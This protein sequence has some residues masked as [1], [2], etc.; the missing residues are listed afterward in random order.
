M[1][2]FHPRSPQPASLGL[3]GLALLVLA[4]CGGKDEPTSHPSVERVF[5]AHPVTGREAALVVDEGGELATTDAAR[6]TVESFALHAAPAPTTLLTVDAPLDGSVFPAAFAPPTLLW[7]D[8]DS[9]ADTWLLEITFDPAAPA[10]RALL[11]GSPPAAGTIDPEAVGE[12]NEPYVP[13]PYQS[14]ARS[15]TPSPAVWGLIQRRSR[16]GRAALAFTGF[17]SDAPSR[18]LSHGRVTIRTTR[19]EL[20]APIFYRDVPL[21]PSAGDT[22][23][24]QPL[25]TN[26]LPVIGWRLRDVARPDSR[27][28][29][30]GM[31]SCANCHSFSQDGKTMGMDVDGPQGDKGAYAVA[32]VQKHLTITK[33]D[34]LTWNS[35]ADKPEGHRTIGFLS[36]VSPNGETVLS[37][38]NESLYVANFKDYRFLQVFFPTRGILAWWSR[39]TGR[40]QALPGADDP[41]YVHCDPVWSPDGQTVVFARAGAQDPYV[42]GRPLATHPNDPNE[43]QIRYDLYR[44]PFN[45]GRGGRPEPIAG[46]SSNGMSN[47]FPKI[48]P[49]GK[50]IVFVK[51]KNGQLMRP[52]GR[53]WI[54]PFEGGKAREMHCNTP[55]MNS[56]H[57][58]SPDSRWMVFS[59]KANTPYTQLFLTHIDE[60]GHDSPAILI[61]NSTAAN[62]AA[63]LPEFVNI[64]YDDLQEIEV[65]AANH[66][67]HYQRG[68]KDLEAGKLEGAVAHFDLALSEDPEFSQAHAALA[69]AYEGLGRLPDARRHYE[70]AL[71]VDARNVRVLNNLGLVLYQSG[72][73]AAAME[74]WRR[75]L[76]VNPMDPATHTNI[77]L[78]HARARRYAE[79]MRHFDQALEADPDCLMAHK[80]LA[81]IAMDEGR[82]PD[83]L[84]H[85]EAAIAL[86]PTDP[87]LRSR[88]LELL[89]SQRR[90][91]GVR[92][93]LEA[94]VAASPQD[95]R[96]RVGLAWLLATS[97]DPTPADI[98]AAVRLAEEAGRLTKHASPPALDALGVAYAA[99]GRYD[100]AVRAAEK[101][102]E[103]A[104]PRLAALIRQR[105][106]LYREQRPYR[107]APH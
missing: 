16:E 9:D 47:T 83:A 46:A 96:A 17:A 89:A 57:S 7:H 27:L 68:R 43:P 106:Q 19:D 69:S 3:L 5:H 80:N 99:A 18:A 100:D 91:D 24:I 104:D 50:W 40:I 38:V 95:A 55:L 1:R 2:P 59:S 21:M 98:E 33:D 4:A 31:S 23:R 56:W 32:S 54:V 58:F 78:V 84:R 75:A 22:G 25:A 53:L 29:L 85:V 35:F 76:A 107:E 44:M 93:H 105:I 87:W 81:V 73:T 72:E 67:V 10:L 102:A 82:G 88:A 14:S 71:G 103:K 60:D 28:L 74:Y 37:T 64:A 86:D 6:T 94:L 52:D 36:R 49:D 30:T 8:D 26:A 45:G 63:N 90:L 61:P 41:D 77:G 48:S 65:P 42:E 15:W 92:G 101:A 20:T 62:R 51:C 97:Q 13:T 66:H 70:A 11:P 12:N 34:V 39:S 79:A